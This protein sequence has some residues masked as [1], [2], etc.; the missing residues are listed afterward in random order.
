M[1]L[2][3]FIIKQQ[4]ASQARRANHD[5]EDQVISVRLGLNKLKAKDLAVVLKW[6]NRNAW[7]EN[8]ELTD[9]LDA[10]V[11]EACDRLSSPVYN[12]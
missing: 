1:I 10:A 12:K 2:P 7:F 4:L 6:A 9:L 3:P 11:R 5:F 8:S